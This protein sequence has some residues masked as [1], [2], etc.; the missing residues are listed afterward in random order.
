MR[1]ILSVLKSERGEKH[2]KVHHRVDCVENAVAVA[3]RLRLYE[4][5]A[6]APAE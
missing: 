3:T 6:T 5:A 2:H 1:E 4:K